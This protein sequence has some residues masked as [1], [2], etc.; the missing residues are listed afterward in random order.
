MVEVQ[1]VEVLVAGDVPQFLEPGLPLLLRGLLEPAGLYLGNRVEANVFCLRSRTS[2]PR[3]RAEEE[4]TYERSNFKRRSSLCVSWAVKKESTNL[5]CLSI[6]ARA[7]LTKRFSG[8]F[9]SRIR[10]L[11]L[12][13]VCVQKCLKLSYAHF[14]GSP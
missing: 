14:R 8:R 5:A 4:L 13:P 3:E 1:Q 6:F 9:P 12:L 7:L 11:G 10:N 2:R